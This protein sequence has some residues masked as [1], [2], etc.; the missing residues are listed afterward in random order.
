MDPLKNLK[1]PVYL[2]SISQECFQDWEAFVQTTLSI[3]RKEMKVHGHLLWNTNIAFDDI[4]KEN[5][6]PGVRIICYADDSQV[7]MVEDDIPMLQ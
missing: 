1:V 2:L 4:L 7:V 6:P 3:I 5:I